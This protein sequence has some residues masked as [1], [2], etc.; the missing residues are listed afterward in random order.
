MTCFSCNSTGNNSKIID[1]I[2]WFYMLKFKLKSRW[3]ETQKVNNNALDY[4]PRATNAI[5]NLRCGKTVSVRMLN[6]ISCVKSAYCMKCT[7]WDNVHLKCP[8]SYLNTPVKLI[9]VNTHP[10]LT[11]AYFSAQKWNG[12]I[13]RSCG[14]L[15]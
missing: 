1:S 15:S 13:Q 11:V 3:E 7:Y 6:P 14:F 10:C 8:V 5:Y 4:Q 9:N 12:Y 2:H